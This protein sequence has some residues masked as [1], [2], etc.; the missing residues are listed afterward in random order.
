MSKKEFSVI[1][2]G[3][4]IKALSYLGF[5][6]A[7]EEKGL[8]PD[9]IGGYSGGAL[10]GAAYSLG[11]SFER[12][13]NVLGKLSW[14]KLVDM[15]IFSQRSLMSD[16][17]ITSQLKELFGDTKIE[18]LEPKLIIFCSNLSKKRLDYF[19]KGNLLTYT[20]ASMSLAPV[21]PSIFINGDEYLDAA[22][23]SAFPTEEMHKITNGQKIV[24]LIPKYPFKMLPDFVTARAK[25]IDLMF[26]NG[27]K[28]MIENDPPDLMIE[29]LEKDAGHILSFELSDQYYEEG[30]KIGQKSYDKLVRF[31]N[32]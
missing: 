28:I 25:Y 17:K 4:G 16:K 21:I 1:L 5:L 15:S 8:K 11:F 13:K 32:D 6:H 27:L 3:G 20:R 31:L 18:E 12:I 26:S 29:T 19:D 7:I 2:A 24:G 14:W 9:I 10:I 30:Y 22:Y 23:I